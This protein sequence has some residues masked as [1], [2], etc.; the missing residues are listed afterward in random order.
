MK[1]V[2]TTLD[3]SRSACNKLKLVGDPISHC[4]IAYQLLA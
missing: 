4:A 2:E 1:A 3:F